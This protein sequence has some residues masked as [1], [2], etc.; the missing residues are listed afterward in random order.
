MPESRVNAE[1]HRCRALQFPAGKGGAC[2]M[3][4]RPR[5]WSSP[6]PLEFEFD[7]LVA[8]NLRAGFG[9]TFGTFG[10]V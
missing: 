5:T 1:S 2:A 7:S 3:P 8:V 4:W 6:K 10:Y 9:A